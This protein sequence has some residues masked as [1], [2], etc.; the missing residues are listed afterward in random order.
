LQALSGVDSALKKNNLLENTALQ[1]AL[2]TQFLLQI[3]VFTAVPMI[4][5]FILEQGVLRAIISFFTMQLQLSSVYF[6]FSLGT[7]THYFGRTILH[8][9][10]KYKETGRGFVVEH[11]PFAENYRTYSRS[12]FVKAMEII[13]LLIVYLVYGSQNR[14]AASYVLL[15]FSSWFL[16]ISWLYAPYIFNPSGFEW[17]KTVKDFEDWT[18]WL[19]HKGGIG[20]QGK[21]SWEVWWKEEIAHIQ[22]TRGRFWEIVLSTRFFIFQYGV[23]YALNA[24]GNDKSFRVYG[25]SWVVLVGIF[26]LFKIFTFSQKASANFQLI[27]RLLQGL[28]FVAILAGVTV[29]I[30][31]TDLTVGDVFASSLAF[32]PTGWGLLCIAIALRPIMKWVGLWSS[33]RGIARLYD[34]AMGMVVFIPIA[35][36]SWFPFVSTFQTRLV[37]NQAFSRGLEISVLLAGDNPNRAL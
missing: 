36:L 13:I 15:T 16:A 27:V 24:A 29:A 30:V 2:E 23:V 6:T 11:I 10:A 32:I 31:L 34:A 7:R 18:N 9:G 21:N 28:I 37:F 14:T 17:Q 8:G 25:Y 12:H 3:G 35:L 1:S 19:F 26:I 20:D 22:T 5:N 33:V 4:V